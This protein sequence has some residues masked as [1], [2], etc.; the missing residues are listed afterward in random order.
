MRVNAC[1]TE[2]VREIERERERERERDREGE[3]EITHSHVYLSIFPPL[4]QE[5]NYFLLFSSISL[6]C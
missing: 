2:R 4:P 1:V 5:L 3:F 6:L